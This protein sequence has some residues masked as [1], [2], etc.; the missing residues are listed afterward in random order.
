MSSYFKAAEICGLRANTDAA[1]RIARR[2]V[3]ATAPAH[4]VEETKAA[5]AAEADAVADALGVR[6]PSASVV[7]LPEPLL[8][9]ADDRKSFVSQLA[10]SESDLH[11][12]EEKDWSDLQQR[13]KVERLEQEALQR[14]LAEERERLEKEAYERQQREE[15]HRAAQARAREQLRGTYGPNFLWDADQMQRIHRKIDHTVLEKDL[16]VSVEEHIATGSVTVGSQLL[17]T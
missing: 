1:K 17:L 6:R 11:A 13:Q 15:E 16:E 14:A 2:T 9:Y 10:E 3:P 8:P 7:V 12:R 4:L 5:A